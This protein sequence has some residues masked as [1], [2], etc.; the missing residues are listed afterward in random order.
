MIGTARPGGDAVGAFTAVSGCKV[1]SR[2]VAALGRL[3]LV[4]RREAAVHAGLDF[5]MDIQRL[6][7]GLR[8]GLCLY[9]TGGEGKG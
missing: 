4:I 8:Q 3:E 2:Q 9:E 5:R 1:H 6:L 7:H